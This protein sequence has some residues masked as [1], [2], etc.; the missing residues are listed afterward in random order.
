MAKN[1]SKGE[2]IGLQENALSGLFC[3][4]LAKLMGRISEKEC[5]PTFL[6]YGGQITIKD[7][8]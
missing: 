3:S 7:E 8:A 5:Y 6:E 2:K 4:L 1:K